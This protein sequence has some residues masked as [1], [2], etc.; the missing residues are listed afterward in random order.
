MA[1]TLRHTPLLF[2]FI[3]TNFPPT[4]THND[5]IPVQEESNF[6]S[7][8]LLASHDFTNLHDTLPG[9]MSFGLLNAAAD[10]IQQHNEQKH[11]LNSEELLNPEF[12]PHEVDFVIP[13]EMMEAMCQQGWNIDKAH[14]VR[15]PII[16]AAQ[17]PNAEN[18]N[19]ETSD[20]VEDFLAWNAC[21]LLNQ[22]EN[23]LPE[24][25]PQNSG[26]EIISGEINTEQLRRNSFD[27]YGTQTIRTPR[28]GALFN[29]IDFEP[30]NMGTYVMQQN[31][32]QNDLSP[33]A[34]MIS[35]K[36]MDAEFFPLDFYTELP[37]NT[38]REQER[39]IEN[40]RA[41]HFPIAQT[42]EISNPEHF[43]LATIDSRENFLPWEGNS[44]VTQPENH[45]PGMMPHK[46]DSDIIVR[47]ITGKPL[48]TN[49]V[50][51]CDAQT[52]TTLALG[53]IKQSKPHQDSAQKSS[54]AAYQ[55][56]DVSCNVRTQSFQEF[57][58]HLRSH[59]REREN[60][61]YWLNC[62]QNF[63]TQQALDLHYSDHLMVDSS[64][65]AR[66]NCPECSQFFWSKRLL[67]LHR[68]MTH[69]GSKN[70]LNFNGF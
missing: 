9:E 40:A 7:Q 16:Q 47:L 44:L 35:S 23:E 24:I 3:F 48:H 28:S 46:N 53:T 22:I 37:I 66:F 12:S 39:D 20:N 64:E 60:R 70:S 5:T 42:A 29:K 17:I 55:C 2:Y 18:V 67:Q 33:D 13:E 31:I 58:V 65:F 62:S 1:G 4:T 57:K 52:A 56:S 54:I 32:K 30:P 49:S 69:P 36:P 34:L 43:N 50:A 68:K 21:L 26:A 6:R 10:T 27:L 59:N 51:P 61:C 45:P 14:I 25:E 11:E 63:S 15:F 41:I 8:A 19:P 38:L